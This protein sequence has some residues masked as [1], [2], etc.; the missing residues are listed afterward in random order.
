MAT[1]MKLRQCQP[2]AWQI[3]TSWPNRLRGWWLEGVPGV[4]GDNVLLRRLA[5]ASGVGRY[6]T[7]PRPRRADSLGLQFLL[8][9]W[10]N[11]V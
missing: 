2:R 8:N 1:I 10:N 3:T 5:R 4:I 9:T 11:R 7:S 6:S